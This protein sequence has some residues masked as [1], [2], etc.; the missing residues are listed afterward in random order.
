MNAYA[1]DGRHLWRYPN[2]WSDVHGSHDAP[3]PEPG[4]MQG[5]MAFLGIA[6]L[7]DTS[8]VVFVNG[9]HGRCFLL[10]TDGFYLDEAFVDVRVSYLKNEYRLGGE[11]FG[12]SFGRDAKTGRYLVQI[13]HGPYRIY[14][15]E[16][17]GTLKRQSGKLEVTSA[18][19]ATA[20][21]QS[22]R[23]AAAKQ[24]VREATIPGTI[25]WDKSGKFKAQ[26][27][28]S[29]DATH[30]HLTWKVQD[31]SPWVNN[32]RDWSKLFATGDTVD[33]QF[34]CDPKSDPK[35]REPVIGDKRL[36]IA[37][38]EGKPIAVLYEH[39][40]PGGKNPIEF[41]S[42]WRGA[43]VDD[44]RQIPEAKITVKA[45]ANGYTLTADIPLADL[46]LTLTAGQTLRADFGVTFGDAAG[47]DTNLRSYWS[48]QSTGLVDDIPGEIM[49]TPNLW[50]EVG[51]R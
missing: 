19:M 40:K 33:F 24:L 20:E 21:R 18:Q 9:N 16:G 47:T 32:G 34:A 42:P 31:A 11:I 12:G 49:L 17:F 25:T 13:G 50:G 22:L 30:L 51:V 45:E 15:L 1:A 3:L 38:H 37:P 4:V 36:L 14:E 44:V 48:N 23:A 28:L 26:V 8:D 27:D 41:T 7:D 39:R 35:R 29:A 43:K 46:G 10:S 5:T 6:P 2:Q